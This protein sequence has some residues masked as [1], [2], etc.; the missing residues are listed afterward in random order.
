MGFIGTRFRAPLAGALALI[1]LG[2]GEDAMAI[3]PPG[4]T[5]G[6][7]LQSE[8]DAA[9]AAMDPDYEP[10]THLLG[11]D[12]RAKYVNRLIHEPSPYLLQHAHNPVDWRPWGEAAFAEAAERGVP[13]FLSVGYAT[14]HWCHV[15]EEE[16]FDNEE[17]AAVLNALFVPIKLDREQRPDLDQVYITA[18]QLQH[19]HAG[20]PNS[21]FLRPDGKPFHTGTYFPKPHF[22][23][24][25]AAVSEAWGSKRDDI[26]RVAEALSTAIA[27]QQAAR[28]VAS[29]PPGDEAFAAAVAQLGEMS[30]DLEGGFS[31]GQQF[32]QE[33]FLVFL[34]DHWRRTGSAEALAIA[35]RSLDAIAAGGIHDHA[36]GGF[37]RYTVDPN[38][39]TPHFEKMLYNQGQLGRAF[40][41]G[42]EATGRLAYARAAER[43]FDYVL[44]EM[45]DGV[46]AFYAAEDADSLDADGR[47]EEG[48]FYTWTPEEIAAIPAAA[49]FGETLGLATRPTLDGRHVL[50]LASGATQDWAALA[51][52]LDALREARA[53]RPR[54]IRDEKI[55]AGWNG[56]MIRALADGAVA[57]SRPVYRAAAARAGEALW[58]RLWQPGEGDR[59]GRLFRIW[60]GER[61]LE[62]GQLEDYAWLGLGFLALD[63]AGAEGPWRARALEMAR[64]A[65]AR[66]GDGAGRLRMAE[67]DGP[68]GPVYDSADGA[69]PAGESSMLELLVRAGR[70]AQDAD[71]TIRAEELRAAISAQMVQAPLL[72][73]EGLVASRILDG[74]PS[75]HRRT[76]A[77]GTLRATLRRAGPAW[78]MTLEVAEGWHMNAHAPGPDWLTGAALDGAEIAWPAGYPLTAAFA[79][80]PV[81]VYA[82]ALELPLTPTAPAVTL[83]AQICSDTLCLEPLAE[84]FRLGPAVQ[85]EATG[86]ANE[87]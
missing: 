87:E 40:V 21:V 77:Q 55:I 12:G 43:A 14:C 48:A 41:E 53:V 65:T 17:V 24:V 5:R 27:R 30:N 39:R 63:E 86:E 54:P 42:W 28:M 22:L 68:V 69:T 73:P 60:A 16:S 64:A 61:A 13:L 51:P 2:S 38:W 44:R 58:S 7:A 47:R 52:A 10:R 72:R 70:A 33:T 35:T 1:H 82:G 8:L 49:P 56:L 66:F 76:L 59:P 9:Y 83:H 62:P 50:H 57:L 46:G 79:D 6:P 78:T 37:H 34:L 3:D 84:T 36:G 32:P 23:Q 67:A 81:A 25:L 71:L 80:E 4:I 75:T 29:P 20:W 15:M 18:T 31:E 74:S 11:E 26:D 45:S 85:D 19:G